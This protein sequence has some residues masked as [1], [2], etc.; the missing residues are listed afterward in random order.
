MLSESI[1]ILQIYIA[2]GKT[3]LG[4]KMF[5]RISKIFVPSVQS[6]VAKVCKPEQSRVLK[7]TRTATKIQN[8]R[9]KDAAIMDRATVSTHGKQGR[10]LA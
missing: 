9:S 8:R 1:M 3:T 6:L 7:K 10:G 2:Q 4:N 5:D